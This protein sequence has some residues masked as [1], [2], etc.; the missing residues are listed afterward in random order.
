[1]QTSATGAFASG[2][3]RW[4]FGADQSAET[5]SNAGSSFSLKRFDD[6]GNSIE[7]AFNVNRATGKLTI[8]RDLSIGGVLIPAIGSL[9]ANSG[10]TSIT[11]GNYNNIRIA[12]QAS[13]TFTI[14][15]GVDGQRLLLAFAQ[16]STGSRTVTLSTG[17]LFG[18]DLANFTATTAANKTDLVAVS[19]SAVAGGWY[20]LAYARGY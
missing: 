19:Y 18:T 12:M 10:A 17:F 16:D 20:V 7:E 11:P 2:G 15:M 6:A 4:Q 5:G 1:M 3:N 8:T 14:G 13:S 9:T